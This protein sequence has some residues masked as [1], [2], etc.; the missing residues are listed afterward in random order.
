MRRPVLQYGPWPEVDHSLLLDAALEGEARALP[1]WAAWQRRS[2]RDAI[3]SG[4]LRLL[5][6]VYRNLTRLGVDGAS[7]GRVRGLYRQTWYRNQLIVSHLATVIGELDRA[8]VDTLALKGTPL[9]LAYYRDLAARPMADADLLVPA[10]RARDVWDVVTRAGWTPVEERGDWPPRFTGS[11]A[12]RNALG[13]E[14]DLHTHVLHDCLYDG[15]DDDFWAAARTMRVGG[16][17]TRALSAADQLLHV[18]VHGFRRSTVAPVRW[19]ADTA[20]VVR[21]SGP[22][23]DWVRLVEQARRRRLSR[24]VGAALAYVRQRFDVPIPAEPVAALQAESAG[25][26]ERLEHWSRVRPGRAQL[27]AEAWCD[28][29]RAIGREPRWRGPLGF[30]RYLQDRLGVGSLGRLPRAAIRKMSPRRF[31]MATPRPIE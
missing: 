11:R 18:I 23:L 9:A 25:W 8:G 20:V 17:E 30:P 10:A 29:Q 26:T 4:A 5:P 22:D 1:A 16:V 2:D 13:L 31:G 15:A 3:D 14:M 21:E 6:L 27:A 28:Y 7:L 19:V 24:I 12:F